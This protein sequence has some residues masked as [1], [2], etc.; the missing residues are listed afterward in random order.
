MKYT[1]ES[2]YTQRRRRWEAAEGHEGRCVAVFGGEAASKR[3]LSGY[4]RPRMC[5]RREV[6]EQGSA[7]SCDGAS[8]CYAHAMPCGAAVASSNM[9]PG[10]KGAAGA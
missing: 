3:G 2:S 7:S 9:T 1:C 4:C 6:A 8:G 5:W 10:E